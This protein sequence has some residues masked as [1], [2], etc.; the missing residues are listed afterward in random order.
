VTQAIVLA[1]PITPQVPVVGAS[2]PS[3]P[4]AAAVRAGAHPFAVDA[5]RQHGP[6]DE[7]EAGDVRAGRA[8]EERGHGLVATAHEDDGVQGLG[9]E[10]RFDVHRHEVAVEHAGGREEDFAEGDHGEFEREPARLPHA[11][12]HRFRQLAES[13]MAVV[14]LA[15]GVDDAD[16]GF[17]QVVLAEPHGLRERATQEEREVLVP[18]LGQLLRQSLLRHGMN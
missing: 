7:H 8:H 15:V 3:R 4:E 12:L 10:H 9:A 18:V 2:W 1:V 11:P 6:G 16:D 5:A 17:V 13:A 14:E